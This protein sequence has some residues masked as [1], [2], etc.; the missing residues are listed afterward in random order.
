[1]KTQIILS[2]DKISQHVRSSQN[3]LK[4]DT[5][6]QDL[7]FLSTTQATQVNH[8]SKQ[9]EREKMSSNSNVFGVLR[10]IIVKA[11]ELEK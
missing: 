9:L 5:P 8:F 4:M 10:M 1:M 11:A 2:A 7:I 6:Y 3:K